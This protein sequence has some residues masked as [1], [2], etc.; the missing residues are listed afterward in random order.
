VKF[1]FNK[2]HNFLFKASAIDRRQ[3]IEKIISSSSPRRVFFFMIILSSMIATLGLVINNMAVVIGG[4]LVAPILSPLLS[5]ALGITMFDNKLIYRSCWVI[6]KTVILILIF[7]FAISLAVPFTGLD[8]ELIAKL[9]PNLPY[10]YIALAAGIAASLAIVRTD[11][12]EF[13]PGTIIAVALLPPL[14]SIGIGLRMFS[15]EIIVNS[16]GL[17]LINFIGI[18]LAAVVIF[19]LMGFSLQK[20]TADKA[21]NEEKKILDQDKEEEKK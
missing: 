13:L 11:L 7:A 5:L 19:S 4:M 9:V 16:F 3:A 8:S 10:L 14:C 12:S 21:I 1:M 18:I 6:F 20:K 2:N 17:F 15:W